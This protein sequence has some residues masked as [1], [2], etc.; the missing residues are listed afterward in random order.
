MNAD[1]L[2]NHAKQ[3]SD[4][5]YRDGVAEDRLAYRCGMLES[6]IKTLCQEIENLKDELK[7]IKNESL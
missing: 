5:A 1:N 6:Y 4:V 7:E 2:I 3:T